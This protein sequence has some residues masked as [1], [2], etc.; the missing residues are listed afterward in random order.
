MPRCHQHSSYACICCIIGP[1]ISTALVRYQ[2][3]LKVSDYTCIIFTI[4]QGFDDADGDGGAGGCDVG[5]CIAL[6]RSTS[7]VICMIRRGA[8]T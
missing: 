5:A 3:I 1:L 2:Q 6:Q 4:H 7:G 8:G